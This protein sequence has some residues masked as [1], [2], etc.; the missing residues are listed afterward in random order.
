MQTSVI[1]PTFNG[2][3]KIA[4]TLE[5]LYNQS[6]RDFETI[7]IIDGSTDNTIDVV[8]KF[9]GRL[10]NLVIE[11][12]LNGGR[13]CARNKGA[14]LASGKI[15]VFLD[16]DIEVMQD[17]I[18]QHVAFHQIREDSILVGNPILN[19]QKIGMDLFLNYRN[20]CEK[21]AVQNRGEG[22]SQ[23]SF[24]DYIFTTANLSLPKE[25]FFEIGK[26]DER[27]SDSEDFDFS[28]RVLLSGKKIFFNPNLKC[29]H[30]DFAGILI[31]IKRQHQYYQSKRLLLR[32]HPEYKVLV[33]LQFQWLDDTIKDSIK[34]LVFKYRPLWEFFFKTNLFSRL[35][36]SIRNFI[37]SSFIYTH[38]ALKVKR[39][40]SKDEREV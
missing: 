18:E 4:E 3:A 23:V 10:S 13:S 20:Y 38:S 37:F 2:A 9:S 31:T 33:P 22:L 7:V 27:I 28:L 39:S 15:L 6:F 30:N 26:F 19:E 17:N 12:Q 25:L 36:P 14:L 32:L 35:H 21:K 5:A 11:Q 24:Q 1:V 16:D 40:N 29:Y 34:S 8:N